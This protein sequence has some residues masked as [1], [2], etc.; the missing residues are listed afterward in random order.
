M[1][2]PRRARV[3]SSRDRGATLPLT[4]GIEYL[5][6]EVE[7]SIG[8]KSREGWVWLLLVVTFQALLAGPLSQSASAAETPCVQ[9]LVFKFDGTYYEGDAQNPVAL[10]GAAASIE[11]KKA[12]LC[13]EN[14]TIDSRTSSS[15]AM[16]A[17]GIGDTACGGQQYAQI[18]YAHR[19]H[20]DDVKV[21]R[22]FWQWTRK[23]PDCSPATRF[24]SNGTDGPFAGT[25][26][27]F[28]V[29]RYLSDDHL[30]M[31]INDGA[32]D[33]PCNVD[34]TCAETNYDPLGSGGWQEPFQAQFLEEIHSLELDYAGTNA[35]RVDYTDVRERV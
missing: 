24:W 20:T 21:F 32:I 30:H 26:Y 14:F 16:L 5:V 6:C 27:D 17:T 25:T 15:W 2:G 8:M 31:L 22:F 12:N 28:K 35:G 29:S 4:E 33:T 18:G 11:A 10:R 7:R 1:T 34:G 19:I 13:D 23:S 9:G 3:V